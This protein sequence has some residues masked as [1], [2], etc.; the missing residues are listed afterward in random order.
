[1]KAGRFSFSVPSPY[2]IH[3][4]IEGRTKRSLPV[5]MA[6]MA[7]PWAALV[8]YI[9]R[10]KQRSSATPARLGSSSLTQWP[11]C[12][13]R[14]NSQGLLKRLPV[15]L[16]CT[17]GLA[18]GSGLLSSRTSSGL[19]SN[20]SCCDGPPCMC[21]KMMRLA[22]GAKWGAR[23]ASGLSCAA[24]QVLLEQ[25]REGQPPEAAAA[26]LQHV[27]AGHRRCL[28]VGMAHRFS[29]CGGPDSP[30]VGPDPRVS[31]PAFSRRR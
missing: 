18:N 13:C 23:G 22:R 12:P 20:R 4:P 25:R 24:T 31:S 27:P 28:V 15:S 29:R 11:D 14:R 19:Y 26:G 21:R 16:N 17:S 9:E 3:D 6:R 30:A 2:E 5:F 8:P 1:M 10:T 7:P